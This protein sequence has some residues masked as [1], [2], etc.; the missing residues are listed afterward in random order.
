MSNEVAVKSNGLAAVN[1][2]LDTQSGPEGRWCKFKAGKFVTNDDGK[3][4]DTD[5]DYECLFRETR[6]SWK[7]FIE[8]QSPEIHGG[9]LYEGY[10]LPP[11]STL[12]D[13]DEDDWDVGLSGKAEDPW[14]HF[15]EIVLVNRTTKEVFLFATSSMTGRKAVS[16]LLKTCNRASVVN[17]NYVP[18]VKL[19]TGSFRHKDPRIGMVTTPSFAVVG[20]VGG[21][22]ALA[23]AA[24]L[25]DEVPF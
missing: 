9:L 6:V 14:Q 23:T 3:E 4:M 13:T 25:N 7:K 16:A 17:S 21:N 12:G 10:V 20:E 18:I 5:A 2:Y 1:A 15:M 8:G 22:P 24:H 11:R 19:R